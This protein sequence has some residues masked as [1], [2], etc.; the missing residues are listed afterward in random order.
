MLNNF[1]KKLL[2]SLY[3]HSPLCINCG[4]M[5]WEFHH[6]LG[7]GRTKRLKCHSSIF[8]AALVCRFCHMRGDIN[9]PESR[10]KYLALIAGFLDS[11]GYKPTEKDR[12]FLTYVKE[13][14]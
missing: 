3:S 2:N 5:G 9:K 14:L 12:E 6:V 4:R 13:N 7:R 11:Q 10:R 1:N 8:N